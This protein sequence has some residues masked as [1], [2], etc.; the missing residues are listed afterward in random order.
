MALSG[1]S[2]DWLC[3]W[4]NKHYPFRCWPPWD[5]QDAGPIHAGICSNIRVCGEPVSC[6]LICWLMCLQCLHVHWHHDPHRQP[7]PVNRSVSPGTSAARS[8]HHQA[9][10]TEST[11]EEY[12]MPRGR[13]LRRELRE[14]T[15]TVNQNLLE[16]I[17]NTTCETRLAVRLGCRCKPSSL[18]TTAEVM[19]K[20]Q[21]DETRLI[22]SLCRAAP[23]GG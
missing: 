7:L 12:V 9:V 16:P 8:T 5:A 4:R 13:C 14:R 21:I 23:D 18:S 1:W 22:D 3:L 10:A 11:R 19:S 20:Q 6:F 17:S 2:G 15:C